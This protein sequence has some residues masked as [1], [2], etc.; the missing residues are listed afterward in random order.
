MMEVL[1]EGVLNKG[2]TGAEAFAGSSA[3]ADEARLR[4][5]ELKPQ[6]LNPKPSIPHLCCCFLGQ[7]KYETLSGLSRREIF[8]R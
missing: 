2:P 4:P 3:S 6:T 7:S 1:V 8:H 5:P